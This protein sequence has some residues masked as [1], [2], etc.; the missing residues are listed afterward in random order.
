MLSIENNAYSKSYFMK[1]FDKYDIVEA[2]GKSTDELGIIADS[3]IEYLKG[4]GGDEILT[5]HFNEKEILH[6]RDVQDLFD[7]ARILKYVSGIIALAIMIYLSYK[8]ENILIGKT[9]FRGL[10]A[11]HI[12]LIILGALLFTDFNKYFTIFHEIFFTNDLWLLNPQ[13]DLMIQMLPE[14]FF[15]GMAKNIGLSFFVLLSILQIVGYYYMKKG[16]G[17]WRKKLRK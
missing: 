5:P 16:R 13:T 15:I 12:I 4:K 11:N 2:T 17:K 14:P 3:L 10:F 9:L 8:N 1:A 6:M 7:Y